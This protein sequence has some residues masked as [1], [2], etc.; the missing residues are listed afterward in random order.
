M[1]GSLYPVRYRRERRVGDVARDRVRRVR[2]DGC[3]TA[4]GTGGESPPVSFV[5]DLLRHGEALPAAAGGDAARALSPRGRA[6][7]ERLAVQLA[8]TGWRPE[9][10]F[11]SPLTRARESAAIVLAR[12]A[13]GLAAEVMD[14]LRPDAHPGEVLEAL[15]GEGIAAGH[16]LLVGHQ[17]LLG[18]LAA[19]LTGGPAAAMSPGCVVRIGC[20]GPP[21]PGGGALGWRLDPRTIA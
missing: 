5:L 7:L 11:V 8:A 9:R 20:T 10:A 15:A 14:A 21:G 18:M 16:V 2:R 13:P 1:L 6:D 12:T 17:P 4:G 3:L 19:T